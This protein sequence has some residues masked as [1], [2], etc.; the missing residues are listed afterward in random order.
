MENRITKLLLQ[1][2]VNNADKIAIFD[3]SGSISF[4]EL[5]MAIRKTA[6][7]LQ[8]AG[9]RKNHRVLVLIPFSIDLY[10]VTMAI[11]TLGATAIFVEDWIS[12]KQIGYCLQTVVPDGVVTNLKGMLFSRLHP[13][14]RRIPRKIFYNRFR[15][16]SMLKDPPQIDEESLALIS[17]TSG[18]SGT[19][20]PVS[21]SFKFLFHQFQTLKKVKNSLKS[22]VELVTL[23]AFVFI[24]L[25]V[26]ATSVIADINT[27]RPEQT[28]FKKVLKQ[29]KEH[30]VN[31]ICSSPSF[32]EQLADFASGS[33]MAR[34]IKKVLTGGAPVFP[35]VATSLQKAFPDARILVLYGSSEAEPISIIDASDLAGSDTEASSGLRAGKIHPNIRVHLLPI[36][37]ANRLNGKYAIGEILV[38]GPNVVPEPVGKEITRVEI[39][40]IKWHATGDSGYLNEI[41]ELVLT[42][43]VD[44]LIPDKTN[45]YSSFVFEALAR[46]ISGITRAALLSEGSMLVGVVQP[47]LE[48]EKENLLKTLK[49]LPF[50]VGKWVFIAEFPKDKRHGGKIK[51]EELKKMLADQ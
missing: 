12:F 9:I 49:D 17:F 48:A 14:L 7:Q 35:S 47:K 42:G 40:G 45:I 11:N 24:N 30:Q 44:S 50:P 15:R 34:S 41:N 43:P 33:E 51:Y 32:M 2:A 38:A 16:K 46:S 8:Q 19:P 23:P 18:V 36:H 4:K 6:T 5:E 27:L 29:L 1:S 26:G 3:R 25:V 22:D 10:R 13:V 21:R 37:P 20:K 28:K 31:A 39:D